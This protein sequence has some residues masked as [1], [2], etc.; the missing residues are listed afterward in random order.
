M[1]LVVSPSLT[2]R[3]D[4]HRVQMPA[5]NARGLLSSRANQTGGFVPSGSA[6]FSEKLLKGTT[7][8]D[9]APSHRRQ[10]GDAT[11]RTFVTPESELRPLSAK[12]GD[13]IPQRAMVSSRTP[14]GALRTLSDTASTIRPRE[15]SSGGSHAPGAG[16]NKVSPQ[17]K[18]PEAIG[19]SHNGR[20]NRPIFAC[21]NLIRSAH[22]QLSDYQNV[23]ACL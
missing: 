8:L 14:S 19:R 20:K 10:C 21:S 9:S 11:L 12:I 22:A 5:K 2:L 3:T 18:S 1:S 16:V 13:G 23:E 7:H 6:S 4:V 15:P 17:R